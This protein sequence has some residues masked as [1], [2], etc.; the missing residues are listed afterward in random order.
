[1]KKCSVLLLLIIPFLHGCPAAMLAAGV[2]VPAAGLI[3]LG[4]GSKPQMLYTVEDKQVVIDVSSYSANVTSI[5]NMTEVGA[6]MLA[7]EVLG[8]DNL[9]LT[10]AK[11]PNNLLQAA[12]RVDTT[13]VYECTEKPAT[14]TN[15]A[16]VAIVGSIVD[17]GKKLRFEQDLVGIIRTH[18]LLKPKGGTVT[19]LSD[20]ESDD[21]L[22]ASVSSVSDSAD[23]ETVRE[24]QS[25]LKERGYLISS[26]DGVAGN[27]TT[28]AIKEFQLDHD[29]DID[30]IPSQALLEELQHASD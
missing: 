6:V 28:F 2:A 10:Y 5:K 1:M 7:D 25:L 30:G 20:E 23:T 11:W 17:V 18:Q 24:I 29:L 21:E 9:A 12:I 16:E 19:H 27:E 13:V 22:Q 14:N 3:K 15:A 4:L 26:V 8:C